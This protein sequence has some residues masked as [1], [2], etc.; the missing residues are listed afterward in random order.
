MYL[1]KS[2]CDS[3]ASSTVISP[4]Y[5]FLRKFKEYSFL[6]KLIVFPVLIVVNTR[7]LSSIFLV[8]SSIL[9]SL[10]LEM[11]LKISCYFQGNNLSL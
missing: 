7:L 1:G 2:F 6:L 5:I 4:F 8:S 10:S 3:F 9:S 11:F